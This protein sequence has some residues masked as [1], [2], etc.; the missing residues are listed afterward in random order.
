M[1]NI[2]TEICHDC[3]EEFSTWV[4]LAQ[5]LISQR[6][7]HKRES[8]VWALAFLAK[9]DNVREFKPRSPM[10]DELRQTLKDCVREL[11][12]KT[13]KGKAKCPTCRKVYDTELEVEFARDAEVWRDNGYIMTNCRDC[14]EL[15]KRKT[16][17]FKE[18]IICP[19]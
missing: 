17:E 14:R 12:G 13:K 5:H 16:N 3:H 19:R 6:T 10:S 18:Q 7:T 2:M 15:V 9:K 8:V 1:G 4:E 11:S